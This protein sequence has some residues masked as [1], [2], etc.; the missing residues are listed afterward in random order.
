MA[1]ESRKQSLRA[2]LAELLIATASELKEKNHPGWAYCVYNKETPLTSSSSTL[3]ALIGGDISLAEYNHIMVEAG[4][5]Q[6]PLRSSFAHG[7]ST[8][9]WE[10]FCISYKITYCQPRVMNLSYI[11]AWDP[12]GKK[13]SLFLRLGTLSIDPKL[14]IK[15]EAEG[16]TKPPKLRSPRF[17]KAR[18]MLKQISNANCIATTA[19]SVSPPPKP[20]ILSLKHHLQ[21]CPGNRRLRIYANCLVAKIKNNQPYPTFYHGGRQLVPLWRKLDRVA[22]S[23]LK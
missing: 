8:D 3:H 14:Q 21:R 1:L 7:A 11:R 17:L 2:A 5:L 12:K 16:L 20:R 23:N 10:A 22:S 13:V 9:I 18:F 4:L 19:K 15:N 6:K